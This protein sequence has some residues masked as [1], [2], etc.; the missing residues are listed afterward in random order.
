M[1]TD[2]QA[3]AARLAR[4][5]ELEIDESTEKAMHEAGSAA[6]LEV[7][8]KDSSMLATREAHKA[9]LIV[10]G[11]VVLEQCASDIALM[12]GVIAELVGAGQHM[13]ATLDS[14]AFRDAAHHRLHDTHPAYNNLVQAITRAAPLVAKGGND[15]R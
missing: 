5:A 3:L 1:T 6:S 9:Y 2:T 14:I 12:Q 4:Y 13:Q 10:A 11:K 8:N 7:F 15:E